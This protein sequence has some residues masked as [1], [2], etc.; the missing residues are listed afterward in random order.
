RAA[1]RTGCGAW[2]VALWA[3]AGSLMPARAHPPRELSKWLGPQRWER[4]VAGPILSLGAAGDFDDMHIFAPA[5]IH[6]KDPLLLWYC[7]SRGH[8]P[9]RVFRLR[10]APSRDRQN[11]GRQPQTPV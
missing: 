1:M 7:G 11:F 2:V 4:D 5:V 10:L 9:A 6:E 3:A 8:R